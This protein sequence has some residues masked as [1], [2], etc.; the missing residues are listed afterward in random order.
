MCGREKVPKT[1]KAI[2]LPS[3]AC[4]LFW[5]G[6]HDNTL[7]HLQQL[8]MLLYRST[9]FPNKAKRKAKNEGRRSFLDTMIFS[10]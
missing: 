4:R 5:W 10:Y 8:A 6:E 9:L 2:F 3:S 7:I 1:G